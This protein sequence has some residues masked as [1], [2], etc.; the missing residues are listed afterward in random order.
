MAEERASAKLLMWNELGMPEREKVYCSINEEG[1]R[2]VQS[3]WGRHEQNHP[4]LCKPQEGVWILF[5]S[6]WKAN[7]VFYKEEESDLCKRWCW[8]QCGE[9]TVIVPHVTGCHPGLRWWQL[10]GERTRKETDI[11]WRKNWQRVVKD[12]WNWIQDTS[13]RIQLEGQKGEL[14]HSINLSSTADSN[15][16]YLVFPN[17]KKPTL[18]PQWEE[19]RFFFMSSNSPA[20][21]KPSLCWTLAFLQWAFVQ[22]SPSQVPPFLYKIIFL[23]FD[24]RCCLWLC[25]HLHV[26][27]CN[28]FAIPK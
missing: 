16:V 6:W 15:K 8:L 4:G 13:F 11:F 5:H 26:P 18:L 14:S 12:L 9:G 27:N 20:K 7:K 2:V 23:S 22:S 21:E 24:L 28:S 3:E 10:K 1:R 17:R 25:H 19:G